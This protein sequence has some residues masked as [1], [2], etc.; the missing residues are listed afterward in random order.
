MLKKY[1]IDLMELSFEVQH[2]MS[3]GDYLWVT[4]FI[5]QQYDGTSSYLDQPDYIIDTSSKEVL[6]THVDNLSKVIEFMKEIWEGFSRS[7]A[8][9]RR[10]RYIEE[11]GHIS[12]L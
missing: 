2:N 7:A 8:A 3:E 12:T 1:S 6:E 9:D 11:P 4:E 10:I 5:K